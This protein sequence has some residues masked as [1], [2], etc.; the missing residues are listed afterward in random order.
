MASSSGRGRTLEISSDSRADSSSDRSCSS[1]STS[2]SRRASSVHS[3]RSISTT[4][5]TV[6]EPQGPIPYLAAAQP[7]LPSRLP[8]QP[9]SVQIYDALEKEQ[10]AIVNRLQRELSQ[11]REERARSPVP[12][13]GRTSES[14]SPRMTHRRTN[15]SSSSLSR[16]TPTRSGFLLSANASAVSDTEDAASSGPIY[17]NNNTM[18]QPPVSV[19]RASSSRR[20]SRPSF[21]STS[22]LS[23]AEDMAI[24]NLRKEND[25]LKKRLNDLLKQLSD[26]DSQI[27]TL[28]KEL[29][30][31][32]T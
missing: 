10:E 17:S 16:T 6:L 23:S 11:L 24:S 4:A 22:G 26:K 30:S 19:Q 29:D 31:L 27:E 5:S 32:E 21:E 7:T 28:R 12:P 25:A 1:S 3:T 20:S 8:S 18:M 14:S 2:L 15:S 9:T 13:A